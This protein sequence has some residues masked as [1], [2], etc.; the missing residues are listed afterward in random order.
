MT[1]S[2][3]NLEMF[4]GLEFRRYKKVESFSSFAFNLGVSVNASMLLAI[5]LWLDCLNFLINPASCSK[6]GLQL[7]SIRYDSID[8]DAPEQ[9]LT[10]SVNER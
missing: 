5:S 8:A 10:L 6:N 4:F 9:S 1:S 7:Q 2:N 3:V